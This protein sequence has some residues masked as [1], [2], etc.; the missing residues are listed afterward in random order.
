MYGFRRDLP[1]VFLRRSLLY[2]DFTPFVKYFSQI[3][4]F[5]EPLFEKSGFQTSPKTLLKIKNKFFFPQ[6]ICTLQNCLHKK[7]TVTAPPRFSAARAKPTIVV[8]RFCGRGMGV[9]REGIRPFPEVV[10]WFVSVDTEM[11][12][13][14]YKRVFCMFALHKTLIYY[15]NIYYILKYFTKTI[16]IFHRL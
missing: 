10:L 14:I 3:F 13:K 6:C 12:E 11:N 8:G 15:I 7:L 1:P 9:L 4:F 16:E 2:T 5:L